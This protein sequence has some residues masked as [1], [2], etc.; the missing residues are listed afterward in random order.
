[1][2]GILRAAGTPKAASPNSREACN[3]RSEEK[4]SEPNY[5]LTEG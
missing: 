3:D 1:M 4:R 5:R 2:P